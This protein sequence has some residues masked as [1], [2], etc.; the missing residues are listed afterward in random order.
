M[1]SNIIRR[2]S[3]FNAKQY[4]LI[5]MYANVRAYLSGTSICRTA[6]TDNEFAFLRNT[7]KNMNLIN[8]FNFYRTDIKV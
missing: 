6:V 8:I 5:A 7:L 2:A 3:L 4:A 1:N